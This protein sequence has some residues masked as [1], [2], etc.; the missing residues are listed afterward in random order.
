[1]VSNKITSQIET[2]VMEVL[3]KPNKA[4]GNLPPCP[5]ARKAWMDGNV[6]VRMLTT[7]REFEYGPWNKDVTIYVTDMDAEALAEKV[8]WYNE[9]FP[10]YVFLEEHPDLVEEVDGFVVN[11]GELAMIIVQP[12]QHLE[13]ARTA[14]KMTEYYDKWSPE[15]RERILDR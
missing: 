3:S 2:W 11:Q 4:F 8:A 1:M 13:Q 6:D 10:A 15:M 7:W 9:R 5:Y 12:R 14:L